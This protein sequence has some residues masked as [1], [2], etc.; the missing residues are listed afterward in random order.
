MTGIN[1]TVDFLLAAIAVIEAWQF[2]FQAL[3]KNPGASFW[4]QFR[5]I[6]GSIRIRRALQTVAI[7]GLLLLAG[8]AS[9]VKAYVSY[10]M[11]GLF[12]HG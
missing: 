5:D 11:T 8:A 6:S 4:S 12:E 10:R 9:I 7:D 3:R 1:A 2:F